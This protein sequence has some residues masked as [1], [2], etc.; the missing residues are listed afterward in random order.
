MK[1][2][3]YGDTLGYGV[4]VTVYSG[5]TVTVYSTPIC[6]HEPLA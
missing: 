3:G 6:I 1:I 5:V 4:T 2:L